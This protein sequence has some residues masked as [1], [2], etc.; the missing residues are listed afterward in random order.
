V[1]ADVRARMESVYAA[2]RRLP[3]NGSTVTA[4]IRDLVS[5]TGYGRGSVERARNKL[6]EAGWI[7]KVRN[8][9]THPGNADSYRLIRIDEPEVSALWSRHGIGPTA[10]LVYDAMPT[11]VWLRTG[12]IADKADIH[13]RTV[14]KH[15]RILLSAGLVDEWKKPGSGWW[16][17]FD[18]DQY[19]EGLTA[20]MTNESMRRLRSRVRT[21]QAEWRTRLANQNL[22]GPTSR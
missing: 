1:R 12:E 3:S 15:L 19:R 4:S 2:M 10:A 20:A 6:V 5:L 22:V 16:M 21:E 7:E 9:A 17:R 8:P 18:D 11:D 13:K 14:R